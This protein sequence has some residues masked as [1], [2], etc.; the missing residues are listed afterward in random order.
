MITVGITGGIGSGKSTICKV[1]Q[2]LG[3]PVFEAAVEAKKIMLRS[4]SVKTGLIDLFGT[5]I[6]TNNGT[7]D[8]KKLAG[9]I[10]NDDVQL[11]KVN[12]LV[13]KLKME[14]KVI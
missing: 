11:D 14:A 2:L 13:E 10:F 9:I 1:F 8:R 6:Y 12:K 3:T 5:G 7:L 4:S